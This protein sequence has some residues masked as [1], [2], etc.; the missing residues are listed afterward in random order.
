MHK[1]AGDVPFQI[2]PYMFLIPVG[3]KDTHTYKAGED[4]VVWTDKV[5]P[6]NNPQDGCIASFDSVVRIIVPVL[7]AGF[8]FRDTCR[9]AAWSPRP[10]FEP[11]VV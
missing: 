4:V 7:R 5:G 10:S 6:Y 8:C 1:Q 2:H 3:G 9:I 11:M